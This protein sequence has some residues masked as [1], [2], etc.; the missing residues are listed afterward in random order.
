MPQTMLP[1]SL[2]T[3]LDWEVHTK[4]NNVAESQNV[5]DENHKLCYTG[6]FQKFYQDLIVEILVYGL[7]ILIL[8]LFLWIGINL[9]ILCPERKTSVEKESLHILVICNEISFFIVL[10]FL[11]DGY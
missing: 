3:Q 4:L 5:A 8:I 2:L 1:S 7:I 9:T 10:I 11:L 6:A